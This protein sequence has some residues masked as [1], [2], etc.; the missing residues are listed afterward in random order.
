MPVAVDASRL[1]DGVETLR[2]TY[3]IVTADSPGSV[4]EIDLPPLAQMRGLGAIGML[5]VVFST[6][7]PVGADGRDQT[8]FDVFADP[9]DI[10]SIFAL[11]DGD[12]GLSVQLEDIWLPQSWCRDVPDWGYEQARDDEPIQR[13]DVLRVALELF[14]NA[15][16]FSTGDINVETLMGSDTSGRIFRSPRETAALRYWADDQIE[17]SKRAFAEAPSPYQLEWTSDG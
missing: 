13:G 4:W 2:A 6:L 8:R 7:R 17:K 16:L 9:G 14:R 5:G 11:E 12:A 1:V 10:A 3:F 15:F